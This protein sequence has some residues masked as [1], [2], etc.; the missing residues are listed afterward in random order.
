MHGIVASE[1]LHLSQSFSL[2][3]LED[4]LPPFPKLRLRDS[5]LEVCDGGS[6]HLPDPD[7]NHFLGVPPP[8]Q[9]RSFLSPHG[10]RQSGLRA[11]AYVVEVQLHRRV[12]VVVVVVVEV[13]VDVEA[14]FL[15]VRHETETHRRSG[16]TR[17]RT[18]RRLRGAMTDA[19]RWGDAQNKQA[20]ERSTRC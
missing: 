8:Q 12:V 14:R 15:L 10:R 20:D 19:G 17:T 18:G 13:E 9:L 7:C 4:S 6:H 11:D 1:R 5:C 2:C 16:R 3:A